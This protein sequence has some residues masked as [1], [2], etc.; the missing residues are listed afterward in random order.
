MNFSS[1]L[2]IVGFKGDVMYTRRR[3]SWIFWAFKRSS[4][5]VDVAPYYQQ[6]P[7][8]GLYLSL[9]CFE[10]CLAPFRATGELYCSSP[11][12]VRLPSWRESRYP[13]SCVRPWRPT[14][15]KD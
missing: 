4:A 11:T 2:R 7:Y 8:R 14:T 5:G 12:P 9:T 10:S 15:C 13:R 3:K 6:Y 1:V